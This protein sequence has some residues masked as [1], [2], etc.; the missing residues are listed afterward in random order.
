MKTKQQKLTNKQIEYNLARVYGE[1]SQIAQ[2]VDS[3]GTMMVKYIE[4]KGDKDNFANH[5]KPK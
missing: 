1:L 2:I 3:I 4:Y 5:C